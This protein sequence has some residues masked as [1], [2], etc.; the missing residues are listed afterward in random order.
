VLVLQGVV[1][2]PTPSPRRN[3]PTSVEDYQAQAAGSQGS[4]M[5]VGDAET[6]LEEQPGAAAEVLVGSAWYLN[7]HRVVNSYTA[8]NH[9]GYSRRFCVHHQGVT[10]PALLDRLFSV[11]PSTGLRRVDLLAVSSLLL[12]HADV[13]AGLR[14]HPPPGWHVA[15]TGRW[16]T[17]WVRDQAVAA[18]GGPVWTSPGLRV[19]SR[20]AGGREVTLHVDRVPGSG[21]TVVLSRLPWPGYRVDGARALEPTDGYLLTL[22]VPSTAEGRTVTARFSPPGWRVELAA[23]WTGMLA[24]AVW[25]VVHTVRSRRRLRGGR[26]SVSDRPRRPPPDRPRRTRTWSGRP[27]AR[28]RRGAREPASPASR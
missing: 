23:W 9:R 13:P 19:T 25:V 4:L 3:L 14:D 20:G 16:A 7:P 12:L 10:C 8:I 17:T 21:G 1:F 2:E 15:A 26:P 27:A 28:T 5:V 6:L 22:R 24:A 18:A 11:E